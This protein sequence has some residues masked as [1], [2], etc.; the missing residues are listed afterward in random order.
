[1]KTEY[2]PVCREI[3][4][5]PHPIHIHESGNI[6]DTSLL[7]KR[8]E[9]YHLSGERVEIEWKKDFEFTMGYSRENGRFSRCYIGKSTGWKPVY[10]M[11]WRRDSMGGMAILS[12]SVAGVRGLGIYR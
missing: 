3:V 12:D 6:I 2:C 7:D 8:F 10:I 11:L 5:L 1:M 9:K 4:E